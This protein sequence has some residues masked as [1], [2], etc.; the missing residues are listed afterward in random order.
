MNE[1]KH[2][3]QIKQVGN[4]SD[5]SEQIYICVKAFNMHA[6]FT[7]LN[8]NGNAYKTI[9]RPSTTIFYL[10]SMQQFQ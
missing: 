10:H 2:W 1:N 6:V 9:N 7:T 8:F 4:A 5:D 3:I